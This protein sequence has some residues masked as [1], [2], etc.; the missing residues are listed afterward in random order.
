MIV[1]YNLHV[2]KSSIS[3]INMETSRFDILKDWRICR[4]FQ[5]A[6]NEV[7]SSVLQPDDED[8][9]RSR[10]V[11][12]EERLKG[13]EED[14][15]IESLLQSAEREVTLHTVFLGLERGRCRQ[16]KIERVQS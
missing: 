15:I 14:N 5:K 3:V 8:E 13:V 4:D 6:V 10:I 2:R 11:Q 1:N 7:K 9:G 12:Y 16:L